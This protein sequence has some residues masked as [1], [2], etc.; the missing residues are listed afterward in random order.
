MT[1]PRLLGRGTSVDPDAVLAPGRRDPTVVLSLWIVRRAFVPLV[2]AGLVGAVVLTGGR[3]AE[4]ELENPGDVVEGVVSPLAGIVLAVVVRLLVPVLGLAAAYPLS[5][6]AA[7]AVDAHRGSG[8]G[9]GL[10]R[11]LDR[12]HVTRALRELR[13]TRAVREEAVR[14]LG[15]R[16]RALSRA[17]EVVAWVTVPLLAVLVV[18]AAVV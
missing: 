7:I 12:A 8:A 16:G 11:W 5:H 13:S 18:A 3:G 17:G 15:A 2:V 6:R 9:A 14:R 1:G 10:G 4:T